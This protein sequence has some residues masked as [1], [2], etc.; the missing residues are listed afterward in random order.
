MRV[1]TTVVVVATGVAFAAGSNDER[2][3]DDCVDAAEVGRGYVIDRPRGPGQPCRV[4]GLPSARAAPPGA[5]TYV[6]DVCVYRG[7]AS[8]RTVFRED[9]IRTIGAFLRERREG[10]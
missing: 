4:E 7:A 3:R 9:T 1:A 5:G 8:Q 6:L 2:C 10:R